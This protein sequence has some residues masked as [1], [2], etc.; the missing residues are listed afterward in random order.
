MF[1]AKMAIIHFILLAL[2]NSKFFPLITLNNFCLGFDQS[3]VRNI[4]HVVA[5]VVS[6][7][8]MGRALDFRILG[9]Y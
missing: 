4:L 3:L 1:Y 9:L 2:M 6:L 8:L 7:G 5:T